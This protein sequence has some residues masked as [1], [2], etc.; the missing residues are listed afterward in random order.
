MSAIIPKQR[1]VGVDSFDLELTMTNLMY[2]FEESGNYDKAI[3]IGLELLDYQSQ[4]LE[5]AH[6]RLIITL[7]SL[8]L[9]Y[10]KVGD[11]ANT[12][13]TY[14]RIYDLQCQR[15][16]ITSARTNETMSILNS[17]KKINHGF[18]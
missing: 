5:S 7:K 9:Y 15:Y 11:V 4:V 16:G 12:I 8:A 10:E 2:A 17:Y 3:D 13:K 14:E 6:P 1:A 18:N